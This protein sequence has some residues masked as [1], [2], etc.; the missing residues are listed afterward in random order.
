M[1]TLPA[2]DKECALRTHEPLS[3]GAYV[4]DSRDNAWRS[5]APHAHRNATR[6]VVD[7]L[8]TVCGQQ[9]QS[10]DPRNNQHNPNTPTIGRR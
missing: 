1:R 3:E 4:V 10:N 8:R 5:R 2:T 9:K 7:G 6:Q